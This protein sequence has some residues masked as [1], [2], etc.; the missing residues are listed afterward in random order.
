MTAPSCFVLL[1]PYL[2]FML[3]QIPFI[4]KMYARV[5]VPFVCDPSE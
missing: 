3:S 1:V 4:P 2:F 5:F